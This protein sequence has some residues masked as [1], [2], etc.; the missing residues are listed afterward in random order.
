MSGQ[1]EQLQDADDVRGALQQQSFCVARVGNHIQA[2]GLSGRLEEP[3][4]LVGVRNEVLGAVNDQ[5]GTRTELGRDGGEVRLTEE[6][7]A[8]F[9]RCEGA[10]H[11]RQ[12]HPQRRRQSQKHP[13]GQD[14]LGD[15]E[16]A[17]D[18][19][20]PDPFVHRSRPNDGG[21][22]LRDA[23]GEDVAAGLGVG[24]LQVLDRPQNVLG[25]SDPETAGVTRTAAFTPK[26][27]QQ[28]V[29]PAQAEHLRVVQGAPFGHAPAGN[30]DH[31][32]IRGDR[33]PRR[34]VRRW[35]ARRRGRQEPAVKRDAVGSLH[36]HG[37]EGHPALTHGVGIVGKLNP[38]DRKERQD[39]GPRYGQQEDDAKT[40]LENR[41]YVGNSKPRGE[42]IRNS[43]SDN[44]AA[45]GRLLPGV[46]PE[47]RNKSK[48]QMPQTRRRPGRRFEFWIWSICACFGFRYSNFGF[49]SLHAC[50]ELRNSNLRFRRSRPPEHHG[51]PRIDDP[52]HQP[53]DHVHR[54]QEPDRQRHFQPADPQL[55]HRASQDYQIARDHRRQQQDVEGM[56]V[57]QTPDQTRPDGQDVAD[58]DRQDRDICGG[59]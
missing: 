8:E 16:R 36:P 48:T 23:K 42:E 44:S 53:Y 20:R 37:F 30:D 26:V 56:V 28:N 58:E 49:G 10:C 2:F 14:V 59:K 7:A 24:L 6:V 15:G 34:A 45:G 39:V 4:G 57:P 13:C 35:G 17:I 3:G 43:K 12:I 31:C 47:I 46:V 1:L 55:R 38:M 40:G 54:E 22:A 41:L 9:G 18:D 50:F 52:V 29:A 19:D 25:L 5:E 51:Q 21:G 11:A 33:V 27:E 32:G